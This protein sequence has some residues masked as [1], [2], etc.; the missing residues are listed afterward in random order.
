MQWPTAQTLFAAAVVSLAIAGAGARN[1]GAAD[2]LDAVLALAPSQPASVDEV[3][4]AETLRLGDGREVRLAGIRAP[5]GRGNVA[6]ETALRT[7]TTGQTVRAF[8]ASETA[9]R[10]GR[11]AAHVVLDGAGL[12][13]RWIQAALVEA[14]LV[15]VFPDG[16]AMPQVMEQLLAMESRA[17]A[18][19]RGLWGEAGN[20]VL[21]AADPDAITEAFHLVEGKVLAIGESR[22]S[23]FLNFGAD[24]RSD[25]TIVVQRSDRGGFAKGLRDVRALQG[26]HIRV[27]G[28]VFRRGGP[29]IRAMHQ[30][31]IEILE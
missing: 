13:Q 1:A 30:Q 9:D 18:A 22:H 21:Q 12:A 11:I 15:Y 23:L 24:Y 19:G 29:A 14:G 31:V 3:V 5:D 2:R 26:R 16:R 27:R 10:H 7:L 20:R 6:V 4:D 17:R 28:Y 25:F 8:G